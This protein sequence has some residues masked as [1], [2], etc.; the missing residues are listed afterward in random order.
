MGGR[1]DAR[2]DYSARKYEI[3]R[4]ESMGFTCGLRC[5]CRVPQVLEAFLSKEHSEPPM[6]LKWHSTYNHQWTTPRH[7]PYTSLGLNCREPDSTV[8]RA[9]RPPIE[10]VRTLRLVPVDLQPC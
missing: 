6:K 2:T 3:L 5:R 10:E 8:G 7:W 1:L 4:I 9:C